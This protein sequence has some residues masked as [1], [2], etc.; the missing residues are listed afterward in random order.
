MQLTEALPP[1]SQNSSNGS[2]GSLDKILNHI[3]ELQSTLITRDA[4]IHD[5]HRKALMTQ[6]QKQ[7]KDILKKGFSVIDTRHVDTSTPE[8]VLKDALH[9]IIYTLCS[10][11]GGDAGVVMLDVPY[12]ANIG[13][14]NTDLKVHIALATHWGDV[15]LLP[16]SLREELE[17]PALYRDILA[18]GQA[19]LFE[20]AE[21]SQMRE[22]GVDAEKRVKTLMTAPIVIDSMSIAAVVMVNGT[23]GPED[24][25]LLTEVLAELWT[26]NVQPL[27]GIALEASRKRETE[28]KLVNE[29]QI[30]DEIILTLDHIL[31]EV[32]RYAIKN[33][34][35]GKSTSEH[36]W[37]LILQRVSNY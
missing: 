32:V 26:P 36:L 18:H 2:S 16:E 21:L 12:N 8:T 24:P 33:T 20:E 4:T 35:Q 11:F 19:K 15:G 17:T 14:T 3:F 28:E 37:R 34:P 9:H 5:L 22:Q 1:L 13:A 29:S 6:E 23:Y 7:K 27:I 25:K 10:T 30:R 31:D